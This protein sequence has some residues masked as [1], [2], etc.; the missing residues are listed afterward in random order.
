M[1]Q[2]TQDLST[3]RI[4]QKQSKAE[5]HKKNNKDPKKSITDQLN[6]Q[7][8]IEELMEFDPEN[9]IALAAT[10]D[11]IFFADDEDDGV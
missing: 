1:L 11:K 10:K 2:N 6:H 5:D 4:Q 8:F 3:S 7:R 9:E